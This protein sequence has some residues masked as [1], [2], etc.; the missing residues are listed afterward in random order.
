[1]K[2]RVPGS[3]EKQR[4]GGGILELLL[5]AKYH[6]RVFHT[7]TKYKRC[8]HLMILDAETVT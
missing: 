4:K 5:K 6:T 1:M 7:T 2:I 3:D 8:H